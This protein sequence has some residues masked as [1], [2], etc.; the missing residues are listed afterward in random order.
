MTGREL[1]IE[2]NTNTNDYFVRGL[3]NNGRVCS[4]N[5]SC[6]ITEAT[7]IHLTP[8]VVTHEL[9]HSLG[10]THDDMIEGNDRV[11]FGITKISI[12]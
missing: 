2:T 3:A 7:K 12:I 6:T 4:V 8:V 9:G 11:F 5:E 1:Y 10:M